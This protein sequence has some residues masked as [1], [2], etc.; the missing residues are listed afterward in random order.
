MRI[1]HSIKGNSAD[2]SISISMSVSSAAPVIVTVRSIIFLVLFEFLPRDVSASWPVPTSVS[3]GSAAPYRRSLPPPSAASGFSADP[4]CDQRLVCQ[5]L[6]GCSGDEAVQP[7][8]CVQLDVAFVQPERELVNVAAQ[9]LRAGMMIDAENAALHDREDALDAVGCHVAVHELSS[10][11]IDRLVIEE[12]PGEATV[13]GELVSVQS[14]ANL[15]ALVDCPVNGFLIGVGDRLCLYL[16][17]VAFAHPE[18]GRLADRAAPRVQ[19][20][21]LVLVGLDPADIGFVYFDDAGQLLEFGP[22]RLTQPMQQKPCRLLRDPDFLRQLQAADPLPGRD[23]QIHRIDPFVQRNMRPL[24]DS[25]GANREVFLALTATVIAAL[26]GRDPVAQTADRAARAVRPEAAFQPQP[27]GFRVG[28]HPENLVRG[29]GAL[30]HTDP[31]DYTPI[32]ARKSRGVKY[33]IPQKKTLHAAEQSL[34]RRR[35][36][37]A[38]MS[39]RPGTCSSAASRRSIQTAWSSSMRRGPPQT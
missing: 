7:G 15:D 16:A 27:T 14:R 8:Q 12:Q 34:P 28:N 1:P 6:A 33:V 31:L 37:T 36:G 5:P 26:A 9:M 24:H 4:S 25:A 13:S 23:E 2:R 17:T 38:R 39:P 19:L 20:F 30:A 18:N 11:V 29:N 3:G 35:P 22:A 10:A 32:I 21:L